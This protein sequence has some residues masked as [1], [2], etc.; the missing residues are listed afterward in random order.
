VGIGAALAGSL[1]ALAIVLSVGS[2]SAYVTGVRP[3]AIEVVNGNAIYFILESGAKAA[4]DVD[5]LRAGNGRPTTWLTLAVTGLPD[6]YMYAMTA[7]GCVHGRPVSLGGQ[8]GGI[9]DVR[10]GI[11][12]LS[13]G[14]LPISLTSSGIW[15][16]VARVAGPDL[17]GVQGP[18]FPPVN[19]RVIPP[20]MPA[21]RST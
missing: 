13:A 21:C 14:N 7:G 12:M 17:G 4:L 20:G 1:A 8:S 6:G 10:T 19:G 11:L 18:F 9:P 3:A 15:V 5:Y 16:R 2:T